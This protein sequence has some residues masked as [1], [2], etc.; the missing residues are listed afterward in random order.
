MGHSRCSNQSEFEY[1]SRERAAKLSSWHGGFCI[2]INWFVYF[3]ISFLLLTPIW[4]YNTTYL[5][6]YEK[7]V[8]YEK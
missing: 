1:S 7:Y 8:S 5:V 6:S 3:G 2:T 4:P